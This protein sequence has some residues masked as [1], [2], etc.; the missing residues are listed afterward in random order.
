M[1]VRTRKYWTPEQE[2]ELREGIAQGVPARQ[3]AKQMDR[4]ELAL[5][6]RAHALD[7]SWRRKGGGG[8]RILRARLSQLLSQG[9]MSFSDGEFVIRAPSRGIIGRGVTI[10]EVVRDAESRPRR[11]LRPAAKA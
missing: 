3:L 4:T 7:I 5:S 11:L 8:G 6:L 1:A 9:T 10:E 2:D